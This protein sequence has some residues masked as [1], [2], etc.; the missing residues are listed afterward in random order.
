MANNRTLPLLITTLLLLPLCLT[1]KSSFTISKSY[2]SP[3][4]PES[5]I[6]LGTL[7]IFE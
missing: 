4:Q 7:S 2:L 5:P 6:T 3:S 1:L